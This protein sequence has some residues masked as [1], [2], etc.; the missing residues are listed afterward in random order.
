MKILTKTFLLIFIVSKSLSLSG[1]EFK[2]SFFGHAS[3]MIESKRGASILIDPVKLADHS[4]PGN[5][6]PDIV[7]I[8]HLHKDHTNIKPIKSN[9]IILYGLK[10]DDTGEDRFVK[11]DT[12]IHG[13]HIYNIVCN[14]RDPDV[15]DILNTIFVYDFDGFRVAHLGDLGV[16]LTQKQIEEIGELDILM[17]P[18]GGKYTI[19]PDQADEILSKLTIKQYVFPMHYKCEIAD[20]LPYTIDDFL[21]NKLNVKIVKGNKI[22][23]DLND[24]PEFVS[25]VKMNYK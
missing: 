20:F 14:H 3:F 18:V 23:V 4:I 10:R 12:L 19:V 7:T 24:P 22:K 13:V 21:K 2:I 1:Q 25:Y 5:L 16:V 17:I 15:S 8:S 9:P 6:K 11:V